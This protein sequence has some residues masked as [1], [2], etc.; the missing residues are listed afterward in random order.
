MKF[1]CLTN[2]QSM[3]ALQHSRKCVRLPLGSD[4]ALSLPHGSPMLNHLVRYYTTGLSTTIP[5]G[6]RVIDTEC[7]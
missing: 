1:D 7:G 3:A 5:S 4:T 6:G 2:G